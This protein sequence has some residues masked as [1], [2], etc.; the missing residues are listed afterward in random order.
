[1]T[2]SFGSFLITSE[3]LESDFAIPSRV[4]FLA[5]AVY[6]EDHFI[7]FVKCLTDLVRIGQW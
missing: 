3:R 1:M 7:S 4:E 5:A 2:D 6:Y